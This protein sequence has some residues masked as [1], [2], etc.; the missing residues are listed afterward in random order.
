MWRV[1]H[2]RFGEAEFNPGVGNARFSPIDNASGQKIKTLYAGVSIDVAL[3]E[4]VFHDV[5]HSGDL[6]T[7]SISKFDGQVLSELTLT[8][9]LLM[10]KLH[11]PALE[12]SGVSR[13]RL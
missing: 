9:D 7:F 1:H 6:K 4:S 11:G 8:K 12:T 13:K 2:S 3:M 10:A 5:P